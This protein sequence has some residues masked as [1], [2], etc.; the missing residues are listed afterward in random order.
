MTFQ[1]TGAQF[2]IQVIFANNRDNIYLIS[3]VKRYVSFQLE[4]SDSPILPRPALTDH[5][6]CCQVFNAFIQKDF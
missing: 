5:V 6:I 1:S 2:H 3:L 4:F